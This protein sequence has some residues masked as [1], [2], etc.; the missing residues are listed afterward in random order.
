MMISSLLVTLRPGDALLLRAPR[1]PRP[2]LRDGL[3]SGVSSYMLALKPPPGS[4]LASWSRLLRSSRSLY[5][6]R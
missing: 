2:W 4:P 1:L 5:R 6:L 3:G